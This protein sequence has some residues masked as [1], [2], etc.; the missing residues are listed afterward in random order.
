MVAAVNAVAVVNV[1]ANVAVNAVTAV[2]AAAAV[3]A[4]VVTAKAVAA[5]HAQKQAP[6]A[7]PRRQ[8]AKNVHRAM[9]NVANVGSGVSVEAAARAPSVHRRRRLKSSRWVQWLRRRKAP[10]ARR[11]Q[12]HRL[13]KVNARAAAAVA[14]VVAVT[15]AK[16]A[17]TRPVPMR[18]RAAKLSSPRLPPKAATLPPRRPA[19]KAKPRPKVASVN[20]A[21]AAVAVAATASAK[22]ATSSRVKTPTPARTRPMPPP[23]R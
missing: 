21:A 13:P 5:T 14:A 18:R 20:V 3:A 10:P 15:V 6:K 22:G 16:A 19:P 8:H 17:V 9:P 4:N 12:R 23:P 2:A 11:L 1:A 7:A